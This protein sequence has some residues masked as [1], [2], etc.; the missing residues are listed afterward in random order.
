M[1][2][3]KPIIIKKGNKQFIELDS[4]YELSPVESDE[5]SDEDG[6]IGMLETFGNDV[7]KAIELNKENRVWTVLDHGPNELNDQDGSPN[8]IIPGYHLVNRLCYVVTK[9]PWNKE[10][11]DKNYIW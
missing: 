2:D 9:K 1:E 7:L 6:N 3:L 10:D 4:V 5:F 8:L 11:I